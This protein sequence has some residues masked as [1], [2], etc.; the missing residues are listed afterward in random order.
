VVAGFSGQ[1]VRHA[2]GPPEGGSGS[3]PSQLV[4]VT[5]G[6][7]GPRPSALR[8]TAGDEI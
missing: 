3:P 1:E 8:K 6:G 7:Q 2:D 5:C 4:T